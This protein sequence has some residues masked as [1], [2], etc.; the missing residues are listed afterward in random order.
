L[1]AGGF[2]VGLALQVSLGNFVP[3]NLNSARFEWL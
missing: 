1:A 2:A 3:R